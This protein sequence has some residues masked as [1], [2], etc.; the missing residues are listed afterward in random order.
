VRLIAH[1][2]KLAGSH[3]NFAA[4][5]TADLTTDGYRTLK[6]FLAELSK[7]S[8]GEVAPGSM[9]IFAVR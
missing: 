1:Q 8:L 5:R 9:G 2:N 7:L 3:S 4:Y 6:N